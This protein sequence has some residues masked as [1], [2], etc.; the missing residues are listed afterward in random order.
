M[1]VLSNLTNRLQL[2]IGYSCTVK[3]YG[4]VLYRPNADFKGLLQRLLWKLKFNAAGSSTTASAVPSGVCS[5]TSPTTSSAGLADT[6]TGKLTEGALKTLKLVNLR[7]LEQCKT[8]LAECTTETYD[9][10]DIKPIIAK[11]K[12][13]L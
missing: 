4:T 3:K 2:H 7:V 8:F 6:N 12:P 10:L 9:K 11:V 5:T 1:W 13:D